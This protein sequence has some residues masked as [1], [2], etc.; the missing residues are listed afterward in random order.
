MIIP[1]AA[2]TGSTRKGKME[3]EN[4]RGHVKRKF[5][6]PPGDPGRKV[7]IMKQIIAKSGTDTLVFTKLNKMWDRV[8][9]Q[10]GDVVSAGR[11]KESTMKNELALLAGWKIER[12]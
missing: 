4:A 12:R 1:A 5:I 6:E 9:I 10:N 2:E 3:N 7:E 11:V 8:R